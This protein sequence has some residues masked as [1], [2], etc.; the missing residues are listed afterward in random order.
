MELSEEHEALRTVV[1]DFADTELE[2]KAAQWD[3]DAVFPVDAV[4]AM[5]EM[6]LFGIPF[7]EPYGQ[8]GDL[9]GLCAA[10]EEMAGVAQSLPITHKAGVGTG[11]HPLARFGTDVSKA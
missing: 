8:G 9:T 5:G 7:P 10:I 3:R 11:A 1:R 4:R 6:G 2:P